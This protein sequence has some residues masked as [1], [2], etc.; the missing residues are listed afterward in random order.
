[1][2]PTLSLSALWSRLG[3]LPNELEELAGKWASMPKSWWLHSYPFPLVNI[4]EEAEAFFVDAELP[5]LT[6]EQ[7][8][9]FV[10]HGIELTVRGERGSD[11]GAEVSWLR[12]ER[13]GGRFERVLILPIAVDA[14]KVEARLNQGVLHLRLPKAQSAL[15]RRIPV[16]E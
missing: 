2:V 9:I 3:R 11:G 10:R 16:R 14:E 1:M 5:G 15:P 4:R 6:R 8:E 7:I 12:R 13:G